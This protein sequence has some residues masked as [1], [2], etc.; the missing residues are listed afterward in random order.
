[1]DDSFPHFFKLLKRLDF[2]FV[3]RLNTVLDLFLFEA[4][5]PKVT[6]RKRYWKT[7]LSTHRAID[8]GDPEV[9][10]Q[11]AG[12]EAEE[13]EWVNVRKNVRQRSFLSGSSECVA[14][15]PSDFVLC[16][17]EG[18]EQALYFDDHD[19]IAGGILLPTTT[20]SKSE[21][22]EVVAV[23][24]G[25]TNCSEVGGSRCEVQ[26]SSCR[27]IVDGSPHEERIRANFVSTLPFSC[28]PEA[29]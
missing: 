21:G 12:F 11:F 13:D 27:N 3:F 2:G 25:T 23:G 6:V 16:I 8:T 15:L 17:Q 22:V 18:K 10:V 24:E 5:D 20:K 1:M 4:A 7:R 19:K 14:V 28:Q 9:L 26:M 29:R